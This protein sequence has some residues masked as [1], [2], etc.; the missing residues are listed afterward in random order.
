LKASD[1]YKQLLRVGLEWTATGIWNI[2]EPGSPRMG[3]NEQYENLPISA[4]LTVRFKRW[5]DWYNLSDPFNRHAQVDWDLLELYGWS[6]AIDLKRELGDGYYVE[7]K[8]REIHDDIAYTRK[9]RSLDDIGD[10]D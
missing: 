4:E 2:P 8:G 10:L 5:T 7:Y 9:L 6:L 3:L 1:E